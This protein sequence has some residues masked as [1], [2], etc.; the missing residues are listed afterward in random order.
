MSL[1]KRIWVDRDP[2]YADIRAKAAKEIRETIAKYPE[3]APLRRKN[4]RPGGVRWDPLWSFHLQKASAELGLDTII[5]N[6]G[7][8]FRTN[9]DKTKAVALAERR[10]EEDLAGRMESRNAL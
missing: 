5:V 9:S 7:I 3:R 6:D 8:M 2:D 10:W 1:T 4:R